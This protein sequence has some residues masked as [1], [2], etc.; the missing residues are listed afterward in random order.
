MSKR[1]QELILW[2]KL[3]VKFLEAVI[4]THKFFMREKEYNNI[5]KRLKLSGNTVYSMLIHSK[6]SM[7]KMIL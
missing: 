5:N 7:R 1:T 3:E 4:I 2:V 6:M